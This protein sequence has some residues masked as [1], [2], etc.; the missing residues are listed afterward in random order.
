MTDFGDLVQDMNGNSHERL[1]RE[2][3]LEILSA[4]S[5][6]ALQIKW[7]QKDL[8]ETVQ[9]IFRNVDDHLKN[10]LIPTIARFVKAHTDSLRARIDALEHK[11]ENWK[12]VG[13]FESGNAYREGNFCT[14]AGSLWH[15]ECDT[16]SV[17]GTDLSWV[18][19]CKRGK[20]AR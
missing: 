11:T 7:T 1:T 6:P 12:Y 10:N 15:C 8:D 4:L 17:P 13:V 16:S 3:S 18:L 14:H 9:H 20:D 19:C 5:E 2:M